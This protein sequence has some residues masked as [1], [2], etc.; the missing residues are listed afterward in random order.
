MKSEP[1]RGMDP[2]S[3]FMIMQGLSLQEVA[4]LHAHAHA[5]WVQFI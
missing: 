5:Q 1:G 3:R 4:V 2:E